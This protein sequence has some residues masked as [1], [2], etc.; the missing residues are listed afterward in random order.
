MN[1]YPD[2]S[3]ENDGAQ[4]MIVVGIQGSG[5]TYYAKDLVK[6][7][8]YRVLVYAP[9]RHD[10][11]NEPDNFMF[12]RA[13]FT[14]DDF[15]QF[16]AYA[17]QLAQLKEIEGIFVDEFDMLFKSNWDIGFNFNDIVLNHRHYGLFLIG[18]TRRP[19]DIPT[20]VFESSLYSVF[21]SIEAPNARMKLNAIY[22]GL[23][24]A[25]ANLQHGSRAY[26]I[27]K[28]GSP[29]VRFENGTSTALPALNR[30]RRIDSVVDNGA[31]LPD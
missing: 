12:Y 19:Q 15:E 10:F 25:A 20:K 21:F 6:N 23:G 24:D 17:K 2:I 31:Q 9:H 18:I 7:N 8:N 14:Q 16:C 26:I 4:K 11:E 30:Q 27:K 5:K 1:A 22:A 29:P 3:K 28:I 13:S